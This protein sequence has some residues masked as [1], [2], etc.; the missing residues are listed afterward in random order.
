M[1][2]E[3]SR[4]CSGMPDPASYPFNYWAVI[5]GP[6]VRPECAK[7]RTVLLDF[8][9]RN[10]LSAVTWFRSQF[11]RQLIFTPCEARSEWVNRVYTDIGIASRWD[12]IAGMLAAVKFVNTPDTAATVAELYEQDPWS[13]E[14][15]SHELKHCIGFIQRRQDAYNAAVIDYLMTLS[16]CQRQRF[17]ENQTEE[18][19]NEQRRQ[20]YENYSPDAM[21][22]V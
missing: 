4:L 18:W 16:D 9:A 7:Q 5:L 17:F 6:V 12:T 11:R 13:A 10:C 3:H 1:T 21:L 14:P 15:F 22:E 2:I 20:G 8:N 19:Q